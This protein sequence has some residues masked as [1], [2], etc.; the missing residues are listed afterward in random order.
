MKP[1]PLDAPPYE[2]NAKI[3]WARRVVGRWG[4]EINSIRC[5]GTV[6]WVSTRLHQ[7]ALSKRA[8][9]KN[10]I[11]VA[12]HLFHSTAL[13]VCQVLPSFRP[14]VIIKA[15]LVEPL[16]ILSEEMTFVGGVGMIL[17]KDATGCMVV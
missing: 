17:K 13:K 1:L 5:N 3:G 4:W 16:G 6:V 15:K 2:Q 12:P 9:A 8:S 7:C 10:L 11:G 14:G